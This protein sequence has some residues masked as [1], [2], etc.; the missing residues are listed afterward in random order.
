MTSLFRILFPGFNPPATSENA[1]VR[2]APSPDL[3]LQQADK[4]LRTLLQARL[5]ENGVHTDAT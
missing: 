3:D 5:T 4:E 1:G 2:P